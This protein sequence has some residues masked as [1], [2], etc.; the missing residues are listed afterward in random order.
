MTKP[1]T[2]SNLFNHIK[3][4]NRYVRTYFMDARANIAFYMILSFDFYRIPASY[5]FFVSKH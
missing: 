3:T 5:N 2:Q 1:Y 4:S